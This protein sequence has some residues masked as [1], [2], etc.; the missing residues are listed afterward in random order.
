MGSVQWRTLSVSTRTGAVEQ[1]PDGQPGPGRTFDFGTVGSAVRV[2][3][4]LAD[5]LSIGDCAQLPSAL[6]RFFPSPGSDLRS[7]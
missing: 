7:A 5:A 2:R 4:W 6:L 3:F 1:L